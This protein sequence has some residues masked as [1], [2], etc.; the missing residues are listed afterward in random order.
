MNDGGFSVDWTIINVSRLIPLLSFGGVDRRERWQQ[1]KEFI[2]PEEYPKRYFTNLKWQ[3]LVRGIRNPSPFCLIQTF[4]Y[5]Y[6]GL[7]FINFQQHLKL[8]DWKDF[9]LNH[10]DFKNICLVLRIETSAMSTKAAKLR[11]HWAR[12]YV[13]RIL[14]QKNPTVHLRKLI[15]FISHLWRILPRFFLQLMQGISHLWN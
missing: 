13:N 5:Y 4:I 6:R 3:I 8:V 1:C 7:V 11:R 12:S 14:S 9:T 10:H 15:F 2:P